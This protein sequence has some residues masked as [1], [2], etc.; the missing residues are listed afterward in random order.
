M[1][2]LYDARLEIERVIAERK[3]DSA[4]TLG[5]LG[6]RS[7]MLLFLIKA[8]TPDDPVKLEKLKKA[9][10]DLLQIKL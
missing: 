9:A 8:E 5:A 10:A 7:G 1:G 6:L 2:K 3:L 4:K